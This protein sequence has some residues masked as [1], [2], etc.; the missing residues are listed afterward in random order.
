MSKYN[1]TYIGKAV[2]PTYWITCFQVARERDSFPMC[3]FALKFAFSRK[4][5]I[6]KKFYFILF[7][8]HVVFSL[9]LRGSK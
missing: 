7:F 1:D 6:T 2:K 5:A 3:L 9:N 8:S 4:S